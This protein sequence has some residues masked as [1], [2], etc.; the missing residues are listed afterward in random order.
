MRLLHREPDQIVL[1][2]INARCPAGADRAGKLT[3][4][5]FH[6][7]RAATYRQAHTKAFA[8]DQ[9]GLGWQADQSDIVSAE[10]E[11]RRQ[12]GTVGRAEDEDVAT[13]CHGEPPMQ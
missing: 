13:R 8:V 11:L 2:G 7:M 1:F 9:V 6:R 10:Q 4:I 5:E 12:Q 3:R